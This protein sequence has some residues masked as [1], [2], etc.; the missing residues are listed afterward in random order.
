MISIKGLLQMPRAQRDFIFDYL[1]KIVTFSEEVKIY[2]MGGNKNVNPI[3]NADLWIEAY[4]GMVP[5]LQEFRDYVRDEMKRLGIEP[6]PE[7]TYNEVYNHFVYSN[8][9]KL[10]KFKKSFDNNGHTE[11][12]NSD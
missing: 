4:I 12:H 3:R 10:E 11:L 8:K 5:E 6:W 1:D 7:Y 9:K 2:E